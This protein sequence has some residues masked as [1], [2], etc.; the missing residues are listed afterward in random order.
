[1][2]QAKKLESEPDAKPEPKPK[3]EAKQK[4][5][6]A[7]SKPS[8]KALLFGLSALILILGGVAG[9]QVI[10]PQFFGEG[11]ES[12]AEEVAEKH[13]HGAA[14]DH[15]A[16]VIYQIENIIVN[17]AG[18]EGNR[19][20]M[21]TVAFEVPLSEHEH[22]LREQDVRV[23]DKVLSILETQTMEMLTMPGAR[24]SLKQKLSDAVWPMVPDAEWMGV[25]LPQYVIQ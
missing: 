16:G 19:F 18:E 23:R 1:M 12:P 25:Y 6:A 8:R 20:L 11:E 7:T 4:P 13:P 17:P 24:D 3:T 2:P 22:H 21:A 10:V 15:P 9:S 14:A 5:D